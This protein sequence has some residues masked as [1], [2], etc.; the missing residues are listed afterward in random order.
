MINWL[1][2]KTIK[3]HYWIPLVYLIVLS[4]DAYLR[5]TNA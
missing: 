3:T 5:Y 4:L 1:K 2:D